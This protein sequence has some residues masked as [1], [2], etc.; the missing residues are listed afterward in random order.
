[1]VAKISER[2]RHKFYVNM[3][4]QFFPELRATFPVFD[5]SAERCIEKSEELICHDIGHANETNIRETLRLVLSAACEC[6]QRSIS[7]VSSKLDSDSM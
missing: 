2:V 1:M 7:S 3:C 4:L 5:V 6:E